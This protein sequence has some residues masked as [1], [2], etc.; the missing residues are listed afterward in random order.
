MSEQQPP[1]CNTC[2]GA[3]GRTVD[4]SSNGIRRQNWKTCGT[5]HGSG[6]AGGR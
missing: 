1:P 3:G 5:C 4:T 2:Q 6:T